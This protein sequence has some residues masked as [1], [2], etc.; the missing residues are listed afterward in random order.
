MKTLISNLSLILSLCFSL[1]VSFLL[2]CS[3]SELKEYRVDGTRLNNMAEAD[4]EFNLLDPSSSSLLDPSAFGSDPSSYFSSGFSPSSSS[5][6]SPSSTSFVSNPSGSTV[7]SNP[8]SQNEFNPSN[9]SG[10]YNDGQVYR[11]PRNIKL[12]NSVKIINKKDVDKYGCPVFIGDAS[13]IISGVYP[14]FMNEYYGKHTFALCNNKDKVGYMCVTPHAYISLEANVEGKWICKIKRNYH[15]KDFVSKK[16]IAYKGDEYQFESLDLIAEIFESD[17][18]KGRNVNFGINYSDNHISCSKLLN[19]FVPK[20]KTAIFGTS[21]GISL[22]SLWE[23]HKDSW[24]YNGGYTRAVNGIDINTTDK[25]KHLIYPFELLPRQYNTK[26][27]RSSFP[28]DVGYDFRA[29]ESG[30][31]E[32]FVTNAIFFDHT[33]LGNYQG[34]AGRNSAL[35]FGYK[36]NNCTILQAKETKPLNE[37]ELFCYKNYFGDSHK[38]YRNTCDVFLD[39][40]IACGDKGIGIRILGTLSTETSGYPSSFWKYS[41]CQFDVLGKEFNPYAYSTDYY[42]SG[43]PY[44]GA[45]WDKGGCNE[46]CN[47]KGLADSMCSFPSIPQYTCFEQ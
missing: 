7:G 22:D 9:F 44:V 3:N 41:A 16:P 12:P 24:K 23:R 14:D 18:V 15:Y 33:K 26:S 35:E 31:K 28:W 39:A 37:E 29:N 4:T 8:F 17:Q 38:E 11:T 1:V 47:S 30:G 5:S 2:S 32:D 43:Y 21:Y 45:L 36:M 10:V 27:I 42:D 46:R 6:S 34:R 25:E 19:K 13:S 20:S 40:P